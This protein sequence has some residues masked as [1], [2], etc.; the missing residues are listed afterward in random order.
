[1]L[2]VVGNRARCILPALAREQQSLS[3]HFQLKM[4]FNGVLL[5]FNI[6]NAST[7]PASLLV[8]L[9]SVWHVYIRVQ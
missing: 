6:F 4:K 3:R 8:F 1:M 2:H 9:I 7:F 5:T